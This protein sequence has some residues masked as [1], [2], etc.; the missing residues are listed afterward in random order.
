VIE[1]VGHGKHAHPLY[2]SGGRR[3]FLAIKE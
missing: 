1:I 2:E 3:C